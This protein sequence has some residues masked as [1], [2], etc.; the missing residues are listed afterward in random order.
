MQP[1]TRTCIAYIAGSLISGKREFSLFDYSRSLH[2]DMSSL[3]HTLCLSRSGYTK[4]VHVPNFSRGS[5]Y[6][7]ACGCGYFF[8]IAVQGTRVTIILPAPEILYS[9]IDNE[10]TQVYERQ[11]GLFVAPDLT[12]EGRARQLAEEALVDWAIERD[13]FEQANRDGRL[14]IE[15]LLRSL[16]FTDIIIEVR[17]PDL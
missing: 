8:D 6:R 16:G 1:D 4:R 3:P 2:V 7:Y 13:I 5:R 12:L 9:R 14:Q 10:K 17:E 15:N 11:T